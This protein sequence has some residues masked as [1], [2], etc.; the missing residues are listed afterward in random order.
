MLCYLVGIPLYTEMCNL[1]K[2]HCYAMNNIIRNVRRINLCLLLMQNEMHVIVLWSLYFGNN[3]AFGNNMRIQ[4]IMLPSR[5]FGKVVV[6]WLDLW[7]PSDDL[8]FLGSEC[9]Q[10]YFQ[11]MCVCVWFVQCIELRRSI[12]CA[13]LSTGKTIL[14]QQCL[15]LA[16]F[17]TLQACLSETNTE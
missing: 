1:E 10:D 8:H 3:L 7:L 4:P 6:Y 17:R 15:L 13:S 14:M 2:N 12:F 9:S 16:P 5:S 11:K